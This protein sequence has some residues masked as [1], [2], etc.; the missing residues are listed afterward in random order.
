MTMVVLDNDEVSYVMM[1]N[2]FRNGSF[3]NDVPC[4]D[5][6]S[7]RCDPLWPGRCYSNNSCPSHKVYILILEDSCQCWPERFFVYNVL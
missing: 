3:W 7:S 1:A 4:T 6:G 2:E 5:E